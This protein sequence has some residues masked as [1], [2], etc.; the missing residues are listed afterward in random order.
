[1]QNKSEISYGSAASLQVE[2]LAVGQLSQKR[3]SA[4]VIE[5]CARARLSSNIKTL[6]L[7]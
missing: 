6:T 2:Y 5:I 1:M 4:I 7:N 3:N